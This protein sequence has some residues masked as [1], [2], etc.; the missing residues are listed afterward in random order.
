[1]YQYTDA[2]MPQRNA[3]IRHVA[4][5]SICTC[6]QA[7]THGVISANV[8]PV[9]GTV[10]LPNLRTLWTNTAAITT[11]APTVQRNCRRS[12]SDWRRYHAHT[13]WTP[14]LLLAST[15]P[16]RMPH[17]AQLMTWQYKKAV[18]PVLSQR[19]P[20]D[21][22]YIWVHWKF[23]NVHRKFEHLKICLSR[24]G[25]NSDWSFGWGLWTLIYGKRRS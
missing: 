4:A 19:W 2:I 12:R 5:Y 23:L 22:P 17:R 11:F 15:A 16:Q 9:S 18:Q 20:H 3:R 6:W 24:S 25:D 10:W 1:M 14:P 21:P 8:Q 13:G 7:N